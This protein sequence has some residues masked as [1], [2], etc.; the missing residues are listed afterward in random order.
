MAAPS[1]AFMTSLQRLSDQGHIHVSITAAGRSLP[2]LPEAAFTPLTPLLCRMHSP[3]PAILKNASQ[4]QFKIYN[5]IHEGPEEEE[6]SGGEM[7]SRGIE[8]EQRGAKSE[9]S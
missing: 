6:K 3:C 2:C 8:M 9:R 5:K 4:L 7:S 1:I